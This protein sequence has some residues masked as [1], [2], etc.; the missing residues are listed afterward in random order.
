MYYAIVLLFLLICPLISV[1]I[2]VLRSHALFSDPVVLARWWTFWAA[3]V[4]LLVAGVRQT[5]QPRF[6]AEE[7]F[8]IRDASAL[9][10]VR[11]IGFG[12]LAMGTLATCSVLYAPWVIPA[13]AVGGIYYGLAALGHL[14]QKAKNAKEY[15][16]MLSDSFACVVLLWLAKRSP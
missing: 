11:E 6:T 14:P 13:A 8:G 4:R 9:P 3:G 7:I 1:S 10:L 16:A 12:N 5:V 2:E 15:T